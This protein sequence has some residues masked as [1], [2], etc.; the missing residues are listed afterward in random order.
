MITF[1]SYFIKGSASIADLFKE[2]DRCGIYVLNFSN[3]EHY[4][5]KTTDIVRRYSQ[6]RHTYSDIEIL[7]FCNISKHKI[8]S[9]EMDMITTIEKM[10][11]KIRNIAGTETPYEGDARGSYR[12]IDLIIKPEEQESWRSGNTLE[13]NNIERRND[14]F[15]RDEYD[16][17]MRRLEKEKYYHSFIEALRSYFEV[18]IPCPRT[19]EYSMYSVSCLPK[20]NVYSRININGQ[21]VFTAYEDGGDLRISLH[22]AKKYIEGV[23]PLLKKKYEGLSIED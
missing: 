21:E 14:P 8:S 13:D 10:G 16:E 17:K 18:G 4:V 3:G 23:L 2:K 11:Y 12:A 22:V 19:T 15:Q 5:G 7:Q 6:H 9:V 20:T 1:K